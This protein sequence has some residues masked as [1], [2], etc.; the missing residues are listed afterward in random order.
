LRTVPPILD[1]V[2]SHNGSAVCW[3]EHAADFRSG[4]ISFVL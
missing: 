3:A 2:G 4:A 1:L